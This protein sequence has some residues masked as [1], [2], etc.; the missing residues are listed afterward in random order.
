[1]KLRNFVLVALLSLVS[2]RATAQAIHVV[3]AP[4]EVLNWSETAR[5]TKIVFEPN[6]FRVEFDKASV[7]PEVVPPGWDGGI[8][9]TLWPVILVNGEW[10]TTGAIEFWKGRAGVDGPFSNAAKDWYSKMPPMSSVQPGPG[11]KVGFMVVAGDQRLKDVRSVQERSK[12]VFLTVP[13]NDTG[14]FT[15]DDAPA[16]P[17]SPPV[18]PAPDLTALTN[19]VA[20]L[21]F[22]AVQN[23]QAAARLKEQFD[24]LSAAF[25][26]RMTAENGLIAGLRTDLDTLKAQPL[27][28]QCRASVFG[29]PISCKLV[30]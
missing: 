28:T 26:E 25:T 15:F 21:E 8:Q 23:A 18:P 6:N 29:V 1:M 24:A 30:P 2:T 12:I 13:A 11:Q 3:S 20:D 22:K 10:Y 7:W 17:P 4:A 9:F 19:R 5:I 16:D 14:T 27:L